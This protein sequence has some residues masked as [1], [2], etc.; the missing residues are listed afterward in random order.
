MIPGFVFGAVVASTSPVDDER[1]GRPAAFVVER[2][3]DLHATTGLVDGVPAS[4]LLKRDGAFGE[5]RATCGDVP[6][7]RV[8]T[9]FS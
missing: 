1:L 7:G 4:F 2:A 6:V 9:P 5:V 3:R 8:G